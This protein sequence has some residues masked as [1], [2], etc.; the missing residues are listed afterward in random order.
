MDEIGLNLTIPHL[1]EI[2]TEVRELRS[3]VDGIAG[4]KIAET[5]CC[6]KCSEKAEVPQDEEP[7][8]M[9]PT[10]GKPKRRGRPKKKKDPEQEKLA[11]KPAETPPKDPEQDKTPAENYI[12]GSAAEATPN[13]TE[14]TLDMLQAAIHKR[15]TGSPE[16]RKAVI[17]IALKYHKTGRIADIDPAK[18]PALL[19]EIENVDA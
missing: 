12:S 13:G 6:G 8:E 4:H 3:I 1:K 7:K 2:L 19:R 9:I 14:V 10:T 11:E 17:D 5:K 18:Y 15:T 16:S